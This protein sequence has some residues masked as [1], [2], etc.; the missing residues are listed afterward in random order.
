M[1]LAIVAPEPAAA[2]TEVVPGVS[3]SVGRLSRNRRTGNTDFVITIRND[4]TAAVAAPI[5]LEISNLGSAGSSAALVGFSQTADGVWV[6]PLDNALPPGSPIELNLSVSGL[7]RERLSF[8]AAITRTASS[9]TPPIAEAGPNAVVTIGQPAVLDGTGSSDA[10]GDALSYAWT[11]IQRPVGSSAALTGAA[12]AQPTLTPDAAGTYVAELVVNDGTDFS[13]PDQVTLTTGNATPVADAGADTSGTVGRQ[14]TLSGDASTD[15]NGDSLTYSWQLVSQPQNSSISPTS[16][17]VDFVFTPDVAGSFTA[18]LTVSDGQLTDTDTVS[19]AVDVNQ[20]PTAVAGENASVSLNDLVMLDGS[21]STDPEGDLL[22]YAWSLISRPDGSTASLDDATSPLPKF[23]V[24]APGTYVAQL[25]VN[26]GQSDSAPDTVTLSTQNVPPVANAGP[27]QSVALA[28][29]VSLDGSGSSDVDGDP[30]SYDWSFTSLPSG[31]VASLSAPASVMPSFV[32]D[33]PGTYVVQ[34]AVSD[35][36]E[37]R[38]DTVTIST[39]NTAPVADAGDDQSDV[40]GATITFDG[41]GSSDADGDTFSFAWAVSSRPAE[42]TA[43]LS[44]AGSAAPQ[45]TLDRPGT[46]VI[47]LIVN[48]GQVSSTADT[49]TVTT[50]NSRPV[51]DAGEGLEAFAGQTIELNGLGSSDADFDDLSYSWSLISAPD[52]ST[53]GIGDTGA[54]ETTLRPDLVGTYV[55]Q[56]IVNDGTVDSGPD[57]AVFDILAPQALL[58]ATPRRGAAPLDLTLFSEMLG[59]FGPY[60]YQ[61]DNGVSLQGFNRT[62][63]EPGTYDVSVTIQDSSGFTATKTEIITVLIGPTV[64]ADATPTTGTAP[65]QVSFSASAADADGSVTRYQWDFTDDGVFD[66]SDASSA[67]TQF[68]Y[69]SPGLYVA[70]L[71]VT[72]ND[73]LST[74]DTVT[75]AVGEPPVLNAGATPL[76]GTAPLEVTFTAS[77]SDPDGQVVRFEWDFE[78]DGVT[79]YTSATDGNTTYTYQTGGIFNATA[80]VFDNDGLLAE[81]SFIVS[82]EGPPVSLPRAF[83][84]S[85]EA[86]LTVTFFASGSDFDGSPEYYDWDYNGDGNIDR[87]LIASMNSTYTYNTPGTYQAALTVV[88]D[89]ELSDTKTVEITVLPST[90]GGP[91]EPLTV[92][93]RAVPDNGGAPLQTRLIG[94]VL[95]FDED[96]ETLSWDI[97]GDGTVDFTEPGAAT[98]LIGG[99]LDIGSYS[100]PDYADLNGDSVPDMILGNSSGLLYVFINQS[101]DPAVARFDISDRVLLQATDPT[102]NNLLTVDVG[103]YAAPLFYDVNGNGRLDLLVGNSSGTLRYY[104]RNG[105]AAAPTWIDKGLLSFD[106]GTT[107]DIGSY[108][109]PA[110]MDY[111]ND[112]DLDLIVGT[113]DGQLRLI[114]RGGT[115]VQ[116]VWVDQDLI[117]DTAGTTIDIGSYAAPRVHEASGDTLLDLYVGNS[118]GQVFFFR[119]AGTAPSPAWEPAVTVLNNTGTLDVGSY[120]V[121]SFLNMNDDAAPELVIGDSSGNLDVY[122][123]ESAAQT[124]FLQAYD[125]IDVGSYAAPAFYNRD[126]DSDF[127]LI[128]GDSNGTLTFIDNKGTDTAPQF[129]FGEKVSYPIVPAPTDP[130]APTTALVD[131]GSYANPTAYDY[132][133]DGDVDFYV[134]NSSGQIFLLRNVGAPGA[135]VFEAP[136]LV[137]YQSGSTID[138]GSY[139]APVFFDISNDGLLDMLVG[140]SSG[141]IEV[142]VNTGTNAVPAFV[143]RSFLQDRFG[144]T[145]DVGSYAVPVFFD[146]DGDGSTELFVGNSSGL[147]YLFETTA[148]PTPQFELVDTNVLNFDVGSYANPAFADLDADG[149][150][151]I[152]IG[153]SSGL[154]YDYFQRGQVAVSYTTPGT[155]RPVFTATDILGQSRSAQVPVIVGPAGGPTAVLRADVT[156]G[157]APL[158]VTF[159]FDGSD[160][161]GTVQSFAIDVD[162]DGTADF[163][164][165]SA[166][167]YTHTYEGAGSFTAELVVTDNDGLTSTATQVI[168]PRFELTTTVA[169][170]SFNPIG[171]ETAIINTAINGAAG[172]VQV[173]IVDG[174]GVLVRRLVSNLSR[175]PGT[176]QDAWDGRDENG[177]LVR[178]GAYYV[179][180]SVTVNGETEVFDARNTAVFEELT[181]SRSFTRNFN[182][183][184]GVPVEVGYTIP[185][186]AEVSLYFWTRLPGGF[187]ADTIGPVRTVFLRL[188]RPA[189][190]YTDVWD[191]F[192]DN[193]VVVEPDRQYPVTLWLYRLP[194]N[195]IIVTGNQPEITAVGVSPQFLNPVFNPYSSG[196]AATASVAVTIDKPATLVLDVLNSE[197]LSVRRI[198]ASNRAAGANVVT[199][200]GR[201]A[202]GNFVAPDIYSIGVVAVDASGNRSLPRYGTTV[203]RY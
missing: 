45:L 86:P 159:T 58:S 178:D 116:P 39:L 88:D 74:D 181:P 168:E 177:N 202:E 110:A 33:V 104:E 122:E 98:E 188:P 141:N 109:S 37:T 147:V 175:D 51:A 130:L 53:V 200:D 127:D 26:D 100:N 174:A 148:G 143:T 183:Y 21:N 16:T 197:G 10:D 170:S 52:G 35:G 134:G 20:A 4:S 189:G 14:V 93:A 5:F 165:T 41:T 94:E 17:G 137:T 73:G 29:T 113:I 80:R 193:G 76:T 78:S 145:I 133:S 103:S 75:I 161:D 101:S 176:Y 139:A 54:A 118:S 150:S 69:S 71:R 156:E 55:V 198:T 31:S 50:I 151:D 6:V 132:E 120:A 81:R 61:W 166:G 34:L 44:G 84:L 96:I 36:T 180:V 42:S 70:R 67:S 79:D 124:R 13:A 152:V 22:T 8:D 48:D 3:T 19:I 108:A 164:A 63:A 194:E 121:P 60:T 23:T 40:V 112:G 199:W 46:Y 117:S 83:P 203:V 191:G 85:G 172:Q 140:D 107:I 196:G 24:D 25:I 43:T 149:D 12:N 62:F 142:H 11:L 192:D 171:G 169:A 95:T 129:Q 195:T 146:Y 102:T 123:V 30:L 162:G 66:F 186:P 68:T 131:V 91:T 128:I 111:D 9:N 158:E 82:V 38:F 18:Q 97:D 160:A 49:V 99:R 135:P 115:T 2:E 190:T 155:F 15:P 138:V 179:V 184:E 105:P 87:R 126:G 59:G 125:E 32:A 185:W 56:L 154:L 136:V 153:N 173:D 119:N 167:T 157:P 106:T 64:D 57:T 187:S 114:R 144:T 1:G 7:G 89:D 201:D 27:D 163:T 90:G 77:A 28:A 182:P 47:Q 92:N 65:L 72:D